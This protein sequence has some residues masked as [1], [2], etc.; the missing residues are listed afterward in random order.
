MDGYTDGRM[1][2]AKTM[3]SFTSLWRHKKKKKTI[4]KCLL[5]IK[6]VIRRNRCTSRGITT[7]EYLPPSQLGVALKATPIWEGGKFFP[8]KA[9]LIF[10]K[11]QILGSKYLS[12]DIVSL[13][14]QLMANSLGV[15]IP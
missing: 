3:T 10:V 7:W 13:E 14:K 4:L 9:A 1:T 6:F 8:L 11:I 12:A 15:S 5:I 2:K